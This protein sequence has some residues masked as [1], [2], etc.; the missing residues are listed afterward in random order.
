LC[1]RLALAPGRAHY[2]DLLSHQEVGVSIVVPTHSAGCST[3]F[4]IV[5]HNLQV[6][7]H[8]ME[9]HSAGTTQ[10]QMS[11][12]SDYLLLHLMLRF[13]TMATSP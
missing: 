3:V 13:T 7:H 11:G 2:A 9:S 1:A 5:S 4:L 10:P 8:V 12:H 6:G